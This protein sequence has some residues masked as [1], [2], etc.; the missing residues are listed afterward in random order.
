[1]KLLTDMFHRFSRP[2]GAGRK[3]TRGSKYERFDFSP[4]RF[5][6]TLSALS[7]AGACEGLFLNNYTSQHI[8]EIMDRVGLTAHLRDAGFPRLSLETSRDE[9]EI[10]RLRVYSGSPSTAR[11]VIEIRLSEI[12]FS[13]DERQLRGIIKE[14]RFKVIA[15]EWLNFQNPRGSFTP[16]RPRLPGQARPGLGAV[17][18]IAPLMETF[19]GDLGADAI[20][21]VPEHFHSAVMYSRSFKYVD[22]EREGL[23][24]AVLRD[25]ESYPLA[26]LSWGFV[27][28]TILDAVTNRPLAHEPS[29]QVL[30]IAESLAHYFSSREYAHRV[31]KAMKNLSC[32]FD[33]DRMLILRK[34]KKFSEV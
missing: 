9:G 15:V 18:Y 5:E 12:I 21:D 11:L 10:H 26:D 1:M 22:P 23:M 2:G 3:K 19:A 24:R 28:G 20:L 34:D 13:P 14:R 32:R 6:C 33:H 8:R 25:L 30:P 7:N 31:E 16:E 4:G 27:T 29:E 17:R